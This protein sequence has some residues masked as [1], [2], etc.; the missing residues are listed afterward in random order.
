[1]GQKEDRDAEDEA[2]GGTESPQSSLPDSQA[3]R[4][5]LFCLAQPIGP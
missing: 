3:L 2:G 1:M 4:A 5:G